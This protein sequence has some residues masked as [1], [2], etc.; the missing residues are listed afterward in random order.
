LAKQCLIQPHHPPVNVLGGYRFPGAPT[1]ALSP[2]PAD[3]TVKRSDWT[4]CSPS[5]AVAE[6]LS[7]PDFLKRQPATLSESAE[8]L[9]EAAE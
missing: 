7:I 3:D 2:L 6:D 9:L 5:V 8:C 1:I 4:P